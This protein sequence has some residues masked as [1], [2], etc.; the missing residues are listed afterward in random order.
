[1]VPPGLSRFWGG[2]GLG[3]GASIMVEYGLAEVPT[4]VIAF[5][6]AFSI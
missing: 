1:M 4:C 6:R 3:C 2:Q 5:I